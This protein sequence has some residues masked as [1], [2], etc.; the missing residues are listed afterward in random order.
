MSSIIVRSGAVS[1]FALIS[2]MSANAQAAIQFGTGVEYSS[3]SYGE[4]EDTKIIEVPF[5]ARLQSGK[6]SLRVRVPLSSVDGP[7]GVVPGEDNAGRTDNSGP[8]SINSG[9]GSNDDESSGETGLGD[10]AVSA[11]RSFDLSGAA[12]LDLT[13]KATLPTGDEVK[14]LGNGETDFGLSAELGRDVDGTGVYAMAGY[15]KR[16][17]NLRD[18]GA[19][20]AIGAYAALSS[21]NTS[22]VELNWSQAALATE[23]D[24]ASAT[25]FTSFK[26]NDRIRL[27]VYAEAGLS[28]NSPDF[29]AGIS[30]TWRANVRRP[31]QRN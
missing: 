29:G 17:G 7:G 18:D 8:G 22:G 25:A 15:K 4:V 10:I 6:W 14:D 13:G 2:V 12:Y 3:G 20:A 5:T 16:G 19:Q 23:D 21:V 27:G 1:V 28:D 31:F 30:L 9:G 11:T 24:A 26:L